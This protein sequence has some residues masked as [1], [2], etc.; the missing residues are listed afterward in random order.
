MQEELLLVQ[1]HKD[2][3]PFIGPGSQDME[4]EKKG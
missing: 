4:P 3:P 2:D 1:D